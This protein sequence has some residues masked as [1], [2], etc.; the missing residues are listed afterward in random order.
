MDWNGHNEFE[1]FVEEYDGGKVRE[2]TVSN[3]SNGYSTRMCLWRG[4]DHL[5][6]WDKHVEGT[7]LRQETIDFFM[8]SLCTQPG[9]EWNKRYFCNISRTME[10][11][12]IA[13]DGSSFGAEVGL[14]HCATCFLGL[15]FT[16][17]STVCSLLIVAVLG[18]MMW[19]MY[20]GSHHYRRRLGYHQG[21]LFDED[22]SRGC[23][24]VEMMNPSE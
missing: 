9:P 6:F 1:H 13:H 18:S 22:G 3:S 16:I 19:R 2:C 23:S 24:D 15:R 20:R 11:D 12:D 5:L 7:V 21:Q 4:A 8:E 17:G 14:V 10:G